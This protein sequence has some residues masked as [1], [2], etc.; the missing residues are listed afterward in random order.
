VE[1]SLLTSPGFLPLGVPEFSW[2]PPSLYLGR[3]ITR[4][5]A[6]AAGFEGEEG[7]DRKGE[8]WRVQKACAT[9]SKA[10]IIRQAHPI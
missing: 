7:I 10:W 4:L 5:V 2:G 8:K 3:M 1:S 9:I 6:F